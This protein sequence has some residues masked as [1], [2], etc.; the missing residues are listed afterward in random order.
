M[1]MSFRD[2]EVILEGTIEEWKAWDGNPSRRMNLGRG[3]SLPI[4]RIVVLR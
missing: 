4:R 1:K 3:D 2:D